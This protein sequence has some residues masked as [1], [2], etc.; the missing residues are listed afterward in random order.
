MIRLHFRGLSSGDS[1]VLGPAPWFRVA[2][3][4]IRQGPGGEVVA[5]IRNHQWE[6]RDR[7]FT[8]IDCEDRVRVHFEDAGGAPTRRFGPFGAFF[9]VDGALYAD[10]R[11]LARFTEE[12]QLWH[13]FPTETFWPVLVIEPAPEDR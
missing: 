5:E 4:H 11:M 13:C 12:T 2:G 10:E 1:V 8:R 9:A 3:N 7:F 6:L